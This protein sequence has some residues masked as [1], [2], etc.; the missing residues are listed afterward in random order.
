VTPS[1]VSYRV[2]N[3]IDN[4][5]SIRLDVDRLVMFDFTNTCKDPLALRKGD[6]LLFV[7]FLVPLFVCLSVRSSVPVKFVSHSLRGSTLWRAGAYRI[8]SD[9]LVVYKKFP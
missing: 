8:V 2:E 9:I 4:S 3:T 7:C 5:K 1:V 6:V